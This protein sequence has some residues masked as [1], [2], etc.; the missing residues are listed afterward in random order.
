MTN[1]LRPI[2]VRVGPA[3]LRDYMRAMSSI[4]PWRDIARRQ[5]RQIMVGN[6][7]VGGDAPVTVQTMTNTP[8]SDA[9]AT[10][11][12]IR[13]CEEV[14]VDIIRVSCPDTDS[15]AALAEITRAATVPIVA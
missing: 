14:G 2:A 10:I 11:D 1:G 7:A 9:K 3:R 12:Q 6:V 4:R 13:R 5:S 8:T 15:T